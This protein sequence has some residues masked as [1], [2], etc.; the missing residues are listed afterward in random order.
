MA[1]GN[2][3]LKF[4]LRK[5]AGK[6]PK[7]WARCFG[8]E[9][10]GYWLRKDLTEH[11]RLGKET[12]NNEFVRFHGIL[13]EPVGVAGRGRDGHV[14]Y[15]WFNLERVYDTILEMGMRPFVEYSF[16][17]K[18]L[19]SGEQT[20]FY[21]RGNVTMPKKLGEWEDLIETVTRRLHKRYGAAELR[22]WYFEVWNEPNLDKWFF[23]GT[24][25]DYFRLYDCAAAAVKRVDPH[26]K[27]GGPATA[28]AEWIEDFIEHCR[29]K[30]PVDFVSYHL[31]PTD[32]FF[33][34]DEGM[35]L[36]WMGESFF[37]NSIKRNHEI[38]RSYRDL[39]L[40]IHMTEWNASSNSRDPIHDGPEAA[41][42]AAKAV[43]E[44]AGLVDT[45]SWWTLTDIFEEGGLPPAPFHGGFG[46]LT[47]DRLRKPVFHAFS[48]L[49]DLGE[50]LVA[51]PVSTPDHSAG[52]I[53]TKGWDGS[54]RFLF[55]GFHFPNSPKPPVRNVTLRLSG[56]PK[57]N[58]RAIV[59]HYLIDAAHSNIRRRWQAVG[60]PE[61]LTL[62]QVHDLRGQDGLDLLRS[63]EVPVSPSGE[64]I[65]RFRLPSS[66]VSYLVIR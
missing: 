46:L 18:A 30:V 33:M 5:S 32:P 51:K 31:Y 16:M 15:S 48:C 20:I 40:E 66:S 34:A 57:R 7:Y 61:S 65:Y 58:R 11:H 21:W 2:W 10:G 22:R 42:F 29:G 37:R 23:A 52:C 45:F 27:V 17:P 35:K 59:D 49:Q 14:S 36:N 56:L 44:V 9:H 24:Q 13:S 60:G 8:S 38:A 62:S 4:D 19:A 47:I 28:C 50:D 41:A 3:A 63:A 39:D 26:L 6:F 43:Q 12:F 1:D 25:A 53:P 55:W 64:A 54:G